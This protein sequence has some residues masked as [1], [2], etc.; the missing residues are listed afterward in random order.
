MI[1][2]VVIGF[3]SFFLGVFGFAQII[4]SCQNLKANKGYW[5]TII[6]WSA[7]LAGGFFLVR[8]VSHSNLS[9]LYIGY[10]VSFVIMLGQ[11]KIH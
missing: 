10:A 2:W 4:G 9:A 11:G 3:A 8:S 6:L 7:I 5:I 1:L